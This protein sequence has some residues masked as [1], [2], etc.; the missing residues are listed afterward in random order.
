MRR[1][2]QKHTFLSLSLR[3]GIVALGSFERA[4]HESKQLIGSMCS[5]ALILA[6]LG[7]LRGISATTYPTAIEEL[8][9]FG[10][11]VETTKHLV[12][13]GNIGTAAGCLAAVDLMG[14]AIGV[15]CVVKAILCLHA[16]NLTRIEKTGQAN[17]RWVRSHFR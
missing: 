7:L 15:W 10:V 1:S 13:H 4:S 3:R 14:W 2:S 8:R 9:G 11:E 17:P 5:G 12:T 6:A 16:A